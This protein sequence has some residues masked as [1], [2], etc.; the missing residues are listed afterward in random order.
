MPEPDIT[1]VLEYNQDTGPS[2]SSQG[3][4]VMHVAVFTEP[5][6]SFEV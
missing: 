1:L 2:I 3:L 5:T 4:P 6:K